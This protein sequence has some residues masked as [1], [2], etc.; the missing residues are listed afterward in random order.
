MYLSNQQNSR[1][2]LE[3]RSLLLSG[4]FCT[5][6]MVA[7]GLQGSDKTKNSGGELLV[8]RPTLPSQLQRGSGCAAERQ[9]LAIAESDLEDAQQAWQEAYDELYDCEM[10]SEFGPLPNPIGPEFTILQK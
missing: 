7:V 1:L 4:V 8:I 5:A 6:A 9:A 3:V 2:F 10:E